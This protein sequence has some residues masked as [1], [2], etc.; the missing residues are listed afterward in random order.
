LA[1]DDH[2]MAVKEDG[3][4]FVFGGFVKGS[5]NNELAK[6]ER[7]G[8]CVES[9]MVNEGGEAAPLVRAGHSIV[10]CGKNFYVFGG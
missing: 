4:I 8:D 9:E 7:S 5:R 6:Y 1:R 3:D 10:N 2:A